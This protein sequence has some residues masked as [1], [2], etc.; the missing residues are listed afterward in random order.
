MRCGYEKRDD[1]GW[2]SLNNDARSRDAVG[3]ATTWTGFL[4]YLR[5]PWTFSVD[6][7]NVHAD[8][9]G[10]L[11]LVLLPLVLIGLWSPGPG[12]LLAALCAGAWLPLSLL[13]EM[14]RFF[15]PQLPA[16]CFLAA[17]ALLGLRAWRLR[18]AVLALVGS[19]LLITALLGLHPPPSAGEFWDVVSG[20][21]TEGEFLT[22][23]VTALYP[24]ASYSAVRFINE[25]APADSR[26]LM[27]GD[28]RGLYLE[29][30]FFASGQFDA[31]I[32]ER[33]ANCGGGP[34]AMRE[35]LKGCGVSHILVN[36]AELQRLRLGFR[37]TVEGAEAFDA[38]W[39]DCTE[40]VFD[41]FAYPDHWVTVFRL[42]GEGERPDPAKA[43]D[44]FGQKRQP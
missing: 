8:N 36:R 33:L 4:R 6:V 7:T 13:S 24:G 29:K 30:P 26:V 1:K 3:V 15:M 10:P 21:R 16:F 14:P 2:R 11:F 37:F 19:S 17:S 35:R 18:N 40:K 23:C 41:D 38:F 28:A 25:S 5:H 32:L 22:R 39:R 31:D 34:T 27:V 42:L 43:E 20:R 9:M 44:I 12:R